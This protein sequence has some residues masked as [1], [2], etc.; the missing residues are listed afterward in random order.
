MS[1][2]PMPAQ[3][4]PKLKLLVPINFSSK[5]DLALDY[6]LTYSQRF[7]ADV[8]L[9]HAVREATK[10]SANYGR[11]DALNE[12]YLERMRQVVIQA[13]DRLNA[14][15]VTHTVEDVYRRISAGRPWVEILRMAAGINCDMI[16]MGAPES[17]EF[18]KL[19][20]MAPCSLV[21]VKQK[22]PAFVMP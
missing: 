13:I 16:I 5:S 6:A 10:K 11:I 17:R 2:A 9:F 1:A 14:L 3:V 22:D 19:F 18:N 21:L 7:S 12:E 20:T 15:G 8:Y 4:K